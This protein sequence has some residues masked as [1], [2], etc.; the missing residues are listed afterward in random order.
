MV[1]SAEDHKLILILFVR[2]RYG[3]NNGYMLDTDVAYN[4][5]VT[6]EHVTDIAYNSTAVKHV[7]D[8]IC[9]VNISTVENIK[10]FY[11]KT[12]KHNDSIHSATINTVDDKEYYFDKKYILEA[13]YEN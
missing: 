3:L 13:V 8:A 5:S 7:E 9:D 6:V 12:N 4:Y 10:S 1:L 2:D 11:L